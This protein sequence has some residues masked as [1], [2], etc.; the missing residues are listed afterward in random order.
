MQRNI[1][2]ER[3]LFSQSI[4]LWFRRNSEEIATPV[5]FKKRESSVRVEPT[6]KL[7]LSEAQDLIDE[8][9]QAGL[10][11]AQKINTEGAFEAQGKHLED[12]RKLV[13]Q[14]DES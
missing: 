9:W 4:D 8:L 6:L 12:M 3:S 2:C 1:F 14:N 13:F 11:P 5:E 10:R 7:T